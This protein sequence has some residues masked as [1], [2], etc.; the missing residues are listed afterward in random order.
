MV[1]SLESC[2]IQEKLY[3]HS[4]VKCFLLIEFLLFLFL[5]FVFVSIGE[6]VDLT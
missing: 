2:D 1:F 4:T 5:S 6:L 3:L